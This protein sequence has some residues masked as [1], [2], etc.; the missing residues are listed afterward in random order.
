MENKTRTFIA[1]DLPDEIIKQI[2][3]LQ[4]LI[5][6]KKFTGKLT[7]PEN[8]HLTLK[9]LGEISQQKLN[10]IKSPLEKIIFPEFQAKLSTTGTFNF[11]NQPRIAW[12]KVSGR[13]VFDL[14]KEI[15]QALQPLFKPEHQFM[16]HLTIARIK[17]TKTPQDLIQTI[18]TLPLKKLSFPITEFKLKSSELKPMG[19]V[20]K[21][22]KTYNLTPI[23]P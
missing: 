6:K 4:S 19:P 23:T 16:S 7:E 11:K 8:L 18:K 3:K 10:Q 20:Y 1:I 2:E 21:T 9:F 13:Q 22:L 17:Y 5:S 12:I 15:D 14:Q